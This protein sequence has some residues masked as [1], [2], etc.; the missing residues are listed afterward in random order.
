QESAVSSLPPFISLVLVALFLAFGS[1]LAANRQHVVSN[2]DLH[3]IS[4]KPRHLGRNQD[5]SF[6]LNHVHTGDQRDLGLTSSLGTARKVFEQ[7]IDPALKEPEWFDG[8]HR[9]HP[10]F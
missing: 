5:F 1:F 8:K 10:A 6:G 3:I 9:W 7:P 2:R 4:L